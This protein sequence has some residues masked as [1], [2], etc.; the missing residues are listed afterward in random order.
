MPS[1]QQSHGH[2][3]LAWRKRRLVDNVT[4][5]QGRVDI[6][7]NAQVT[8]YPSATEAEVARGGDDAVNCVT[9]SKLDSCLGIGRAD[10]TAVITLE[11]HRWI[12]A[13]DTLNE[14]C[15]RDVQT[16]RGR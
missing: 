11:R 13:D 5:G 15:H 7:T 8:R 3:D 9:G 4:K 1:S 16:P 10:S 6:A 12:G 2:G 14:V